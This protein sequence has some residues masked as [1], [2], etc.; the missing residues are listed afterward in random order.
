VCLRTME[1][2]LFENTK[3][4]SKIKHYNSKESMPSDMLVHQ[5]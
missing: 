2:S 4:A 5:P 3:M 1:F